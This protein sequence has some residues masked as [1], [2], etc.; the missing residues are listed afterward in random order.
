MYP[1]KVL[2][3]PLWQIQ[4]ASNRE[5]GIDK[6]D[7]HLYIG[8]GFMS[9]S[10]KVLLLRKYTIGKRTEA[11]IELLGSIPSWMVWLIK[12]RSLFVEMARGA[13][14]GGRVRKP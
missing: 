7:G 1:L 3:N 6:E 9:M 11:E 12:S 8:V 13:V 2:G 14:E 10:K 5:A 4:A